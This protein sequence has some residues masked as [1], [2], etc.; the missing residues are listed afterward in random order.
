MIYKFYKDD[1]YIC[2]KQK[3]KPNQTPSPKDGLRSL[4]L[5]VLSRR[6]KNNK[7]LLT[8]STGLRGCLELGGAEEGEAWALLGNWSLGHTR[9]QVESRANHTG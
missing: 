3:T 5:T 6:Y 4:G 8:I 9:I 1:I 7:Y 2:R